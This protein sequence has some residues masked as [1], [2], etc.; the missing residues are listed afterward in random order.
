MLCGERQ[1]ASLTE[2]REPRYLLDTVW[3][4]GGVRYCLEQ[5]QWRFAMRS[6]R[7]DYETAISPEFGYQRAFAKGTDW[8][9]TAA[10][11]QDEYYRTPLLR[12]QDDAGYLYADLDTI[13]V[14]Y[15]S[16][17]TSFGLDFA[18]WP[19]SFREFVEAHFAS[20]VI[21]K[22]TS[23]EQRLKALLGNDLTG[24]RTGVLCAKRKVAKN[25][26]SQLDPTQ[27]AAQGGW[28]RARQGYG[29]RRGP[30]GDGGSP[31][32]LTG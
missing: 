19:E 15:V 3:T 17:N 24:E 11:N 6:A 22:I 25:K 28:T 21:F 32:S 1:L 4:N 31:G 5:A 7:M 10:V 8:V 29:G 14:R 20:K 18:K 9:T 23:D 30:L 2:D 26:N 16:D 12:Y 13:Y 27:F